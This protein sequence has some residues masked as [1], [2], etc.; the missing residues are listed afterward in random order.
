MK[1]LK[2][3]K[4]I[5][6]KDGELHFE[7]YAILE[8]SFFSIY[9]HKIHKADKDPFL[10]SHPWNFFGLILKGSYIE[11]YLREG[12][13]EL[14]TKH[15]GSISFGGR[16]YFHSIFAI[17]NGPVTSLFFTFGRKKD[18]FYKIDKDVKVHYAE[19]RKNKDKYLSDL[20]GWG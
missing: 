17:E 8:T 14:K 4:E 1:I 2:K 20:Y 7:R 16:N 9:I 3:V 12:D 6:S 11:S 5:R 18:W 19:Y 13:R 10:H 15:P